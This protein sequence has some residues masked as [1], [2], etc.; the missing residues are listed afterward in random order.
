MLHNMLHIGYGCYTSIPE[1]T[2]F[3]GFA[4][5]VC[6]YGVK[7]FIRCWWFPCFTCVH[8]NWSFLFCITFWCSV[9]GLF[10]IVFCMIV[11]HWSLC[12]AA[13]AL[14]LCDNHYPVNWIVYCVMVIFHVTCTLYEKNIVWSV[15]RVTAKKRRLSCSADLAYCR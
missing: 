10:E 11:W 5:L 14:V 3:I 7:F 6:R 2:S 13:G 8:I 1:Y 12:G 4:F 15:I 9:S